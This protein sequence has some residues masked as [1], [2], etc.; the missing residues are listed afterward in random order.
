M[1][2]HLHVSRL[3]THVVLIDYNLYTYSGVHSRLRSAGGRRL[4]IFHRGRGEKKEKLAVLPAARTVSLR[5][6]GRALAD[7]PRIDLSIVFA[8]RRWRLPQTFVY[9]REY[10]SLYRQVVD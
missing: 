5:G 7:S 3:G 2:V 6:T 1:L 10:R 8:R 9:K 4:S